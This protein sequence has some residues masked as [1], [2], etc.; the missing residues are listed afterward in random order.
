M[1]VPP[2][3]IRHRL[4]PRRRSLRRDRDGV[5]GP[6]EDL[7]ALLVV[8]IAIALL[9]G[10]VS[11]SVLNAREDADQARFLRDAQRLLRGPRA[12]ENLTYAGSEGVF[13][14]GKV[15]NVNASIQG[16]LQPDHIGVAYDFSIIDIGGYPTSANYTR[17]DVTGAAP[18]GS[19]WI[20]LYSTV[21]IRVGPDE[22]HGAQ[23]IIT[24][25]RA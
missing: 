5:I 1:A 13:D 10:S 12:A 6:F 2:G 24:C 3:A 7:A 18:P 25:W 23:L 8:I 17:H 14:G 22:V 16:E 19:G 9:M 15:K 20:T 11:F 21:V 4:T